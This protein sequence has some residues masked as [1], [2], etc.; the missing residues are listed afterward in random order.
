MTPPGGSA[1][2]GGV[3]FAVALGAL[4]LPALR[5]RL[6]ATLRFRSLLRLRP[7]LALGLRALRRLAFGSLLALLLGPALRGFGLLAPRLPSPVGF[8]MVAFLLARL[9]FRP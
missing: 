5:L 4:L 7:L 8:A 2:L 6:L 9:A 3:A 1:P